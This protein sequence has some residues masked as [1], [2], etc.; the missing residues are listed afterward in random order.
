MTYSSIRHAVPS[1]EKVF[2]SLSAFFFLLSFTVWIDKTQGQS[3]TT[4]PS[5]SGFESQTGLVQDFFEQISNTAEGPQKGLE[6]LLKNSPFEENAKAEMIKTLAGKIEGISG[7][8]GSFVSYELIGTKKIG[9]D[10][11]VLRYLYKCQN[12][13][14]VWYFVFYRPLPADS[15]TTNKQWQIIHL[16][17][18]SQLNIP[19]WESDF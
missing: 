16:Y 9:R 12:Y 3:Q 8:F 14:I 10:L 7:Q 6:T 5:G 18:D 2:F 17:Y 13:P 1:L 11:V 4:P 15:N 19:I